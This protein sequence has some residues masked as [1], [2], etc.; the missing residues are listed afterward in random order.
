VNR[1]ALLRAALR[2][3][4]RLGE[5]WWRAV[6]A[7]AAVD[8]ILVPP[9]NVLCDDLTMLRVGRDSIVHPYSEIAVMA[10]ADGNRRRGLYI[11][12]RTTIGMGANLRGSGGVITIGDGC[13][14]GQHVSVIAANHGLA[15][16][17]PMRGQPWADD[18]VDVLIEDDVHVG[19]G[20]IVLS[21]TVL[22]RGA[23]VAAGAVVRGE[24][25]PY[26]IVAGT[27][28]RPVGVRQ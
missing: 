14:F 12:E 3:S 24:V 21:G 7:Q 22:R 18:P 19:A 11:G 15:R 13:L 8:G 17:R 27:P 9:V 1:T 10:Q 5:G 28:A 26:T 4:G 20:A 6:R 16:D 2:Q 25:E 23:V